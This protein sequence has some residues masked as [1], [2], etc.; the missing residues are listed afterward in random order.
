[1]V[2]SWLHWF[3]HLLKRCSTE[4]PNSVTTATTLNPA[5]SS[6]LT[7]NQSRAIRYFWECS[8]ER[9]L[10][11]AELAE[12]L[13]QAYSSMP[14]HTNRAAKNPDYWLFLAAGRPNS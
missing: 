7:E 14:W 13:Q 12:H 1:M 3:S 2:K 11:L 9:A 6:A 5:S 10:K 8:P 4:T